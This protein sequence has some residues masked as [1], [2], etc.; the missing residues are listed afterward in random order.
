MDRPIK[1][2]SVSVYVV[3]TLWILLFSLMIHLVDSDMEIHNHQ[4]LTEQAT[5][6]PSVTQFVA[7]PI[8]SSYYMDVTSMITGMVAMVPYILHS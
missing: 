7:L 6:C 4:R 8:L 1:M 3:I 2:S 5:T